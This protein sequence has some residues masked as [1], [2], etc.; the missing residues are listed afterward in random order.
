MNT[1]R[2]LKVLALAM[3]AN[4][5]LPIPLTLD[6]IELDDIVSTP[7]AERNTAAT[8]YAKD[9]GEVV[10]YVGNS[11]VVYDRIDIARYW[12][13]RPVIEDPTAVTLGDLVTVLKSRYGLDVYTTEIKQADTVLPDSGEI[14]L[15]IDDTVSPLYIGSTVVGFSK[16]VGLDYQDGLHY[17][18]T[19]ES[20][21]LS[22]I[23]GYLDRTATIEI[24]VD[25]SAWSNTQVTLNR[26]TGMWEITPTNPLVAG[27]RNIRVRGDRIQLIDV[28]GN[29][30]PI[31][32][33][34]QYKSLT[35]ATGFC[36]GII[37][38]RTIDS[39]AFSLR[40]DL[41]H[42]DYM[43]DGCT[44][45]TSIPD[46]L[47]SPCGELVSLKGCFRNTLITQLPDTLLN[48]CS[49]LQ[50]ASS[51]FEQCTS[52]TNLPAR[53]F[54]TNV[55]LVTVA[56]CFNGCTSI[57]G[58]IP[59]T[60]LQNQVNL[61]DVSYLFSGCDW[62]EF[63]PEQLF[64]ACIQL[65]TL[66]GTF[67]G[68]GAI[69]AIPSGLL[70]DLPNINRTDRMFERCIGLTSIPGNFL[71]GMLKLEYTQYMFAS[72]GLLTI[73]QALFDSCRRVVDMDYMFANCTS[74]QYIPQNLLKPLLRLTSA[75]GV[76]MGCTTVTAIPDG[77]LTANVNLVSANW[78]FAKTTIT[79]VPG[80]VFLK[81]I[82]LVSLVGTFAYTLITE[83]TT[84]LLLSTVPKLRDVTQL[85]YKC[86][87]LSAV[88]DGLFSQTPL[89]T[90]LRGTFAYTALGSNVGAIFT[91]WPN[92]S[93]LKDVS[94]IY[95]GCVGMQG[96]F[97][98]NFVA[99]LSTTAVDFNNPETTQGCV[100]GCTLL[101]DYATIGSI[102][103]TAV[104][105]LV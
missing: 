71:Y 21:N 87:Q 15:S 72:S 70:L 19:V 62:V 68:C 51:L 95:Q 99:V 5:D 56:R 6:N 77:L 26:T 39:Q 96:S 47:F 31:T 40:R 75:N 57:V 102:Y 50:D 11:G 45:L 83:M 27:T 22:P 73:P 1:E 52:L 8:M 78:L 2:I 53:L 101:S 17:E 49:R 67:R 9:T 48:A 3:E 4:P 92:P 88:Y 24:S 79:T 74:V 65:T 86:K 41:T 60:L 76:F 105:A 91:Y 32:R 16:D 18:M 29:Y 35:E 80:D 30:V 69:T 64:T 42:A 25:G 61:Q 33:L 23:V 7:S 93:E 81:N 59:S 34:V 10:R 104:P 98:E 90:S 89:I 46:G 14:T 63:I 38:L 58:D 66:V 12:P 54:E 100:A 84:S 94:G 43:F 55:A 82:N 37:T 20:S 103:R 36:A 28:D 97:A 13:Q 85:F 44:G